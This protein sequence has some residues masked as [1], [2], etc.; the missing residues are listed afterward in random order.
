MQCNTECITFKSDFTF[1]IPP[2]TPGTLLATYY[3]KTPP[4]PK[5]SSPPFTSPPITAYVRK[6]LHKSKFKTFS[7]NPIS[8][9]DSYTFSL[10]SLVSARTALDYSRDLPTSFSHSLF[11]SH[12]HALSL[13]LSLYLLSLYL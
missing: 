11:F 3:Q 2:P 8:N 5:P 7:F 6:N 9:N 4:S 1:A 13:S 10:V 12:L